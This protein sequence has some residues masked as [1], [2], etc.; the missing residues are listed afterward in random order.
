VG[1]KGPANNRYISLNP[2]TN[3]VTVTLN[4]DDWEEFQLVPISGKPWIYLI[5]SVFNGKYL[6]AT[7]DSKIEA[8]TNTGTEESFEFIFKTDNFCVRTAYGKYLS[9]TGGSDLN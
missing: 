4:N 9:I 5:K 7:S 2:D 6:S 3:K 8:T 1:L